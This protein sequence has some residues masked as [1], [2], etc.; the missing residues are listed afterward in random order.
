MSNLTAN[1]F[2][3]ALPLVLQEDPSLFAL[4]ESVAEVLEERAAETDAIRI[5]PEIDKLPEPL[6]DVLA[7]DYKVDWYNY[8]YPVE[9]KRNLIKA[10]W[11]VHRSL[12]TTGAVLAAVQAVYPYS[13]VEEW[14]QAWYQ[15]DP[16]HFRLVLETSNPI[17]PV[18]DADL[19]RQLELYR[20]FR[21]VLDGIYY[22][23]YVRIVI[24][25]TCGWILYSSRLCGTFPERAQ[26]GDIETSSIVVET[27]GGGLAYRNPYTGEIVSGTFP[28]RA[29]QG[30]ANGTTLNAASPMGTTAYTGRMCGTMPGSII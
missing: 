30:S 8:D 20:S 28:E 19:L 25:L 22:R 29:M 24:G 3:R 16:Y 13:A 9:A 7:Y 14:W 27:D 5:Y 11:C 17:V 23:S 4:A 6:L 15:G 2:L 10:A 12:G 21:S 1:D 18:T 26:Q